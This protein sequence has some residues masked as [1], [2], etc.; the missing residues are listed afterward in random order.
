MMCRCAASTRGGNFLESET[1]C[2]DLAMPLQTAAN[3]CA[4]GYFQRLFYSMRPPRGVLKI[5][6][7]LARMTTWS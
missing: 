5:L 7:Y 6:G 2:L 1:T 4:P 3:A